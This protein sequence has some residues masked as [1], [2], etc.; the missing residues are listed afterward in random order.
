MLLHVLC[1]S[2]S[3]TSCQDLEW[4][5]HKL[6]ASTQPSG[7]VFV[8]AACKHDKRWVPRHVTGRQDE[9]DGH[10]TA[11]AKKDQQMLLDYPADL[12]WSGLACSVRAHMDSEYYPFPASCAHFC[13]LFS[14]VLGD[15][16]SAVLMMRAGEG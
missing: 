10:A 2:R 16:Q 1:C 7:F 9:E 12:A 4:G 15:C 11:P 13:A 14:Q 8:Q 5:C 6:S 3:Q